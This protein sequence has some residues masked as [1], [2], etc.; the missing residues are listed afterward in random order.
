MWQ[1]ARLWGLLLVAL[2][3]SGGMGYWVCHDQVR[4]GSFWLK[5]CSEDVSAPWSVELPPSAN[6]TVRI[7]ARAC[8][9]HF[10]RIDAPPPTAPVWQA[11]VAWGEAL[12]MPE[13]VID[14]SAMQHCACLSHPIAPPPDNPHTQ[15]P[16]FRAPPAG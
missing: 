1:R 7:D 10:V 11:F 2:L 12:L 13:P 5:V 15:T 3:N 9:C 14:T 8:D 6:D 16:A 4:S